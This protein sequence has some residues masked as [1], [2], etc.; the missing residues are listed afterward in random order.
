MTIFRKSLGKVLISFL[1]SSSPEANSSLTYVLSKLCIQAIEATSQSA[2]VRSRVLFLNP[3]PSKTQMFQ[4]AACATAK[5][6][7]RINLLFD[8]GRTPTVEDHK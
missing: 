1:T 8:S 2:I 4:I 3:S 7:V 5:I 6:P